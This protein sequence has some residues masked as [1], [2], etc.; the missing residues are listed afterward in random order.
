MDGTFC[1]TVDP[2]SLNQLMEYYTLLSAKPMIYIS[3]E[4][5]GLPD[6]GVYLSFLFLYRPSLFLS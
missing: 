1:V 6:V 2:Y 4:S 5:W 3:I